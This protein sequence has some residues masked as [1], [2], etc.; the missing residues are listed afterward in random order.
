MTDGVSLPQLH[1]VGAML[2]DVVE[3]SF[4]VHRRVT[5]T[6][7]GVDHGASPRRRHHIAAS[8]I[9]PT[10]A[11]TPRPIAAFDTGPEPDESATAAVGS[12]EPVVDVPPPP[13]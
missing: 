5:G 10:P 9:A 6:T 3:P 12:A 13:P 11:I 7:V 2:G 8:P 1:L 4:G